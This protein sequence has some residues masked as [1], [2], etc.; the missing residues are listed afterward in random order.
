MKKLIKN[1]KIVALG[2]SICTIS[3]MIASWVLTVK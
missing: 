3:M 1:E 2:I